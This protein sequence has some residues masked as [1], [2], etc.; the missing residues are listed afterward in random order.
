[1]TPR[2][3]HI[4]CDIILMM[5]LL[6]ILVSIFFFNN[7]LE[8]DMLIVKDFIATWKSKP[9]QILQDSYYKSCHEIG[10]ADIINYEWP[11]T[12]EGCICTSSNGKSEVLIGVCSSDQLAKGCKKL[13]SIGAISANKWKRHYLCASAIKLKPYFELN[14]VTQAEGCNYRHQSCGII[15]TLGNILC[16]PDNESCP[17]NSISFKNNVEAHDVRIDTSNKNYNGKIFT[18]FIVAE[19]RLCVNHNEK[20]FIEKD[21]ILILKDENSL[22]KTYSTNEDGTINYE[23]MNYIKLDSYSKKE[24]YEHNDIDK[25][26]SNIPGYNIDQISA[27]VNLYASVYPAWKKACQKKEF[28]NYFNSN[29]TDH[30]VR[31]IVTVT[32]QHKLKLYLYGI[33]AGITFFVGIVILKY[34][35][36]LSGSFKI[37][38][39]L[40]SLIVTVFVYIAHIGINIILLLVSDVNLEVIK[41]CKTTNDF[42]ELINNNNCSDSF[43]NATLRFL[44]KAYFS[45]ANRFFNI[46]ILSFVSIIMS[47]MILFFTLF[48]KN[49]S[50]T[51]RKSSKKKWASKNE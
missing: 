39:N 10:T 17:I 12:K 8:K 32:E 48:S 38:V 35:M 26:I 22:C 15:D 9:I 40:A 3:I 33:G 16:I 29:I 49:A 25:V 41:N 11:G 42:F 13:E 50:D 20:S 2:Q 21:H 14:K 28:F 31:E 46:K 44:V 47:V 27:N 51:V 34:S 37:E 43:T 7:N 6:G 23:D 45:Y 30:E 5:P 1:M 36:I 18:N 24:F 4:G 19:E